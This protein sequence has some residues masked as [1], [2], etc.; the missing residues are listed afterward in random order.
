LII[1]I[2]E[3]LHGENSILYLVILDRILVQSKNI[4]LNYISQVLNC[5]IV[6]FSLSNTTIIEDLFL[7]VVSDRQDCKIQFTLLK[8]HLFQEINSET[9]SLNTIILLEILNQIS[10]SVTDFLIPLFYTTKRQILLTNG[11]VINKASYNLMD[12]YDSKLFSSS[13]S[14]LTDSIITNSLYY[15]IPPSNQVKYSK[16]ADFIF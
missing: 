14:H 6:T 12:F 3:L 10:P 9:A 11:N 2:I 16:I 7:K 5:Q 4:A 8:S 13:S 15:F 1:E